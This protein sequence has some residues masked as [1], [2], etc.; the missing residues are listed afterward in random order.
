MRIG[1]STGTYPRATDTFIQQEIRNL[2]TLGV[3]VETFAVR[4]PPEGDMVGEEQRTERDRTYYLLPSRARDVAHSHLVWA[5]RHPSRYATAF[6][7]ALRMRSPG[8]RALGKQLLY[9]AEAGLLARAVTAHK[10]PHLHNHLAD[11]SCSVALLASVLGGYPYSFTIHGPAEFFEPRRWRLD[12]KVRRA[13]FVACISH[14]C[15]SQVMMFSAS[16]DWE[17]LQ[18]VHCGVDPSLYRS[19]RHHGTGDRL[20]FVGRLTPGKGVSLLLESVRRLRSSGLDVTLTVAGDGDARQELE[21]LAHAKGVSQAVSFVGYQSQAAV[22][23]LLEEADVFVLPSFA[24]GVPVCLMEALATGLAVVGTA[25]GGV[26]EL[27]EHQRSGLL[28]PPGDVDALTGAL[29]RL[30]TDCDLRTSLGAAG[31]TKVGQEFDGLAE[32]AKLR[33][34][35]ATGQ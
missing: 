22:R 25:V 35:F 18:V 24:E 13:S 9:F 11:S 4:R 27:V 31:R 20:L 29:E 10:L 17:K 15:R 19:R 30:I 34:L 5:V 1:Y 8:M 33:D 28:V 12:E 14:F 21:A 26:P 16:S 2:R 3:E 23:Q 6:L 32:A 7:L